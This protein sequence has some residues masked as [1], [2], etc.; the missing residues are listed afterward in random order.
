MVKIFALSAGIDEYNPGALSGCVN[1]VENFAAW[2]A[3]A[4]PGQVDQRFLRNAEATRAAVVQG[5]RDHLSKAGPGDV[6]VFHYAGHGRR[7]RQAV[8]FDVFD[9]GELEQ[10]LVLWDS[11]LPNNYDLADK[12]M[13]LLIEGVANGG[14]E[15]VIIMDCCH[16]GSITRDFD[17]FSG[18]AVRALPE[19]AG[20]RAASSDSYKRYLK[21]YLDGAYVKMAAAG[22]IAIP[23]RRHILLAACDS[24]QKA[25]ETMGHG[26]FT[27]SLVT[28]LQASG[29]KTS[30]A[31]LFQKVRAV[32]RDRAAAQDPQF[33][34]YD[35]FDGW[36]GFLGA[37]GG[38]AAPR[39]EMA[40]ANGEWALKAGV[41]HGLGAPAGQPVLVKILDGDTAVGTGRV[42]ALGAQTSTVVPDFAADTARAYQASPLTLAGAAVPIATDLPADL[43]ATLDA[44]LAAAPGTGVVLAGPDAACRHQLLLANGAI[45]LQ[46]AG[47]GKRIW[48]VLPQGDWAAPLL[49]TLAELA[50]WH[51]ML[52]LANPAPQLNPAQFDVQVST[53]GSDG[54]A[55][56]QPLAC[57]VPVAQQDGKWP[58][59]QMGLKLRNRL[60]QPLNVALLWCNPD[61]GVQVLDNREIDPSDAFT[62]AWGG[63]GDAGLKL[64]D[65]E[66]SFEFHLKLLVTTERVDTFL[67][68]QNDM[69]LP[70]DAAPVNPQA[71]TRGSIVIGK[72]K[73]QPVKN[74]WFT[75]DISIT[76]VRQQ[77]Q[78][79]PAPISLADG[80][81][82]IAAHPA[83]TGNVAL[84]V[85]PPATRAL[86]DGDAV[87]AAMARAGLGL[88]GL[89]SRDLAGG[90]VVDLSGLAGTDSL[91][92]QPLAITLQA[93]LGADEVLVPLLFDG[94]DLLPAGDCQRAEDGSCQLSISA[95]P[96]A[97]GSRSLTGALKLYFF[98][99]V[100]NK[101]DASQLRWVDCS[102]PAPVYGSDNLPGK[103]AA[104][105]K[106]L[107]LVH[108]FIGDTTSIAQGL[109][110]SGL[111]QQFDLVLAWDYE[112]LNTPIA[113]T[114]LALKAR[115]AMAGFGPNDNKQLTIL[116]HSMG[117]LVSRAMIELHDGAAMV[118][119]LVMCGTPNGGSPL[120]R[121]LPPLLALAGN[122]AVPFLKAAGPALA[123]LM[124]GKPPTTTLAQMNP[125]SDFLNSLA[126]AN[127]PGVRYTI[128]SGSVDACAAAGDASAGRL[129][130]KLGQSTPFDVLFNNQPN[131]VAVAVPSIDGVP[132]ARQPAPATGPA[133]A[134]HHLNYF[135][136]PAGLAAL[137]AVAW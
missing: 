52:A 86:D 28:A 114:G 24:D 19:R 43:R 130:V 10:G 29:G 76:L 27:S 58:V 6:A 64:D 33:E 109:I 62:L 77:A 61:Y 117:G 91:A 23:L 81:I 111:W 44:A 100:L 60:P 107:L 94:Q 40:F 73:P 65:G 53:G 15:V 104:A 4:M 48:A 68:A 97:V 74:D 115:L 131:D 96:A 7:S 128:L 38:R 88:A 95:L 70:A 3:T 98:K 79:G 102:G 112:N 121:V 132:A 75:F 123:W 41:V 5:F 22:P 35:G 134:C 39:F 69:A 99:T 26:V 14:A 57:R 47:T 46:D 84:L 113:D 90:A 32:V 63:N 54:L 89:G 124:N 72:P 125:G 135:A 67:L 71:T 87:V 116:S 127:D 51:R 50:D 93:G 21:D 20:D 137:K 12:E 36:A 92:S 103:V 85:Q 2:L 56:A 133:L 129:L 13:A 55:T 120:G 42:T 126:A 110:A 83:M 118:D 136:S 11:Q 16:S 108:G 66:N 59:V 49:F 18:M 8:E 45:T 82:T 30:Y 34:A 31:E 106:V 37:A 78:I 80:A 105:A 122:A 1:D 17:E 9:T 101:A 25:K 119:H